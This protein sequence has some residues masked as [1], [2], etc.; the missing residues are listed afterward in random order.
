MRVDLTP[1]SPQAR[2]TITGV[3]R[4][5]ILANSAGAAFVG[6]YLRLL[7]P[8]GG[9]QDRSEV[10]LVAFLGYLAVFLVL[11]T[12]VNIAML[13]R[14]VSWVREEREPTPSERKFVFHLPLLET[15]ASF[16]TW[17]GAA[18]VFGL[19]N[20]EQRR[21]AV[22]IILAG[23]V[24]CTFLYMLLE[25]HFRPVYALALV[26]ADL[27][28]NRRDVFPR[29]MLAWLLGSG[30]PLAGLGL[31][32]L[33]AS[34]AS[35]VTRLP[36]LGFAGVI[37]GGAV[38]AASAVSVSRPLGRVREALR[39]VEQGELDTVVP[40]DDLG[41]LGRLAEGVND[42]VAG[43]REREQLRERFGRQ[44]GQAEL[45]DVD[46]DGPGTSDQRDVTVLFVD[47][48][49]YTR[50][51]EHHSPRQVVAMLNRFFRVVVAVVN[52]E[53]GWVNKFEGDAA[54]CIFG[55]PG[56]QPDH[57]ARALRA[58]AALPR[59]LTLSAIPLTAGIGVA[60]GPVLAGFIGTPERYEY[61]VIGDVVNVAAR[62]CELAKD[63]PSWAMA[64]L[65]TVEAAGMPEEWDDPVRVRIRGRRE[66]ANVATLKT[67]RLSRATRAR[68]SKPSAR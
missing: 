17:V 21:V 26:D 36:W 4:L 42:L 9:N 66:R 65:R 49:G 60:T 68:R 67:P 57:A 19:L 56:D 41:E 2:A 47:L 52:R 28:E 8:A 59:E 58:A 34:D 55:A 37:G 46:E 5:Q 15:I 27:P 48:H 62:L 24:T 64:D 31:S 29:L 3:I 25:A 1:G 45:A 54:L 63:E 20:S 23:L 38:M 10:S 43:L 39:Q 22:A 51:S 61:T 44:V 30:L 40:V 12:P 32:P 53:G 13:R 35:D 16:V 11:G 6:V 14:A 7:F 33:V 50:Y 18:V